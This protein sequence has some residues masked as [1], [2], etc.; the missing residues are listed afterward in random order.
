M[1]GQCLV[2]IRIALQLDFY[3]YFPWRKTKTK[4][5]KQDIPFSH[6]VHMQFS[7]YHIQGNEFLGSSPWHQNYEVTP[8]QRLTSFPEPGR[9]LISEKP[10]GKTA[11]VTC[12][13]AV[14]HQVPE[15]SRLWKST[16]ALVDVVVAIPFLLPLQKELWNFIEETKNPVMLIKTPSD[17]QNLKVR[18][19]P[20]K[21]LPIPVK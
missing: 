3:Y 2:L 17:S 18:K 11:A 14:L 9:C 8:T 6:V 10:D 7:F 1:T 16:Y 5:L 15:G 20:P 12:L 4:L 13:A 19:D 21:H